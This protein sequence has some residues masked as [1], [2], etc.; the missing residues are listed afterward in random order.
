[1]KKISV[2][3]IALLFLTS[4]DGLSSLFQKKIT[5][6]GKIS[7]ASGMQANRVK[8]GINSLTLT[9]ATKVMAYY[10]N[11]YTL[12]NI[13][14][15]SFTIQVPEG[16]ATCLVFL[17]KNNQFIGNLFAGGLNVLPLVG[18]GSATSIDLSTLTLNGTCVIPANDPIGS[19]I[20]ISSE[21]ISFMQAVGAYYQTLSKNLDM[22]NDSSPDVV[23]GDQIRINSIINMM[24]GTYGTDSRQAIM[25]D[26]A[27]FIV[28]YGI[29]IAGD[30]KMY[31]INYNTSLTNETTQSGISLN[32]DPIKADP[33]LLKNATQNEFI[34]IFQQN[35]PQMG[36][37]QPNTLP[38]TNGLYTFK[39]TDSKRYTFNFS[40]IDMQNHMMIIRPKFHTDKNGYISKISYEFIFPD[41][42]PANPHN[43][44]QGYIRAQLNNN[45]SQLYE[46][47]HLYGTFT[48]DENYD[49]YNETLTKQVLL[50]QV[51]QCNFAY[52]DILGNEY[53]FSWRAN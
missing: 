2:F 25:I 50:S 20:Q 10:G 52:I 26:P 40:N 3:L 32:W 13:N 23:D 9:D 48:A 33:G 47:H 11:K 45:T 1:M 42:T 18:L 8:S 43:L 24:A 22:D 51:D 41:G 36:P 30:I 21:E 7:A 46:G 12:V 39:L 5:I 6:T 16:S 37:S 38:F 15:G 29:R 31:D 4:C 28:N 19:T 34:L 44:I 53:E 35:N 14:N 49:Y 17:D 27:N